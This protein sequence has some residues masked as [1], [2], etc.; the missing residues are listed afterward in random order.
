MKKRVHYAEL[1]D[2]QKYIEN[3]NPND[4][5][6]CCEETDPS[7]IEYAKNYYDKHLPVDVNAWIRVN[8]PDKNLIYVKGL[9]AIA[10]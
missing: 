7:V 9:T 6:S 3:F 1:E 8:E 10:I 4:Y 5:E 2:M